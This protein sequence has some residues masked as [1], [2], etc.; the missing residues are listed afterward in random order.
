MPLQ[1]FGYESVTVSTTSVALTS[2]TYGNAA[3]NTFANYA[4]IQVE[5][6]PVRFRLDGTAPT[7]SVGHLL[8]P[9][10]LLELE[11][12]SEIRGFHAISSTGSSATLRVHYETRQ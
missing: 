10:D 12:E 2:T 11:S 7:A 8:N 9:G 1:V 6:Y 5:T 4:M 3:A